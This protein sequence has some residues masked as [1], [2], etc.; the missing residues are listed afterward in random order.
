MARQQRKTAKVRYRGAARRRNHPYVRT[1]F[2]QALGEQI[3]S[4]GDTSKSLI[5]K[6]ELETGQ[7]QIRMLAEW[8]TG[9]ST[10]RHRQSRVVL[11]KI[12]K[13]YGLPGG[14]FAKLITQSRPS[15]K[16]KRRK[17]NAFK[18]ALNSLMAQFGDS[19]QSLADKISG[20]D[21]QL[22]AGALTYWKTG[23]GV[24]RNSSSNRAMLKK[25]E[26]HYQLEDGFLTSLIKSPDTPTRLVLKSVPV[27][28]R[29]IMKWHLPADFDRRPEGERAEILGWIKQNVE[30]SSTAYGRYQSKA[31]RIG[32]AIV[33]PDIEASKGGR[34]PRFWSYDPEPQRKTGEFGTV[35]APPALSQEMKELIDLKTASLP[36]I[37]KRRY[38]RWGSENAARVARQ[39]GTLFGAMVAPSDSAING[40]DVPPFK[41][42]LGLLAFPAVWEWF[43]HWREQ[44]RGFLS[45]SERS[46]LYDAKGLLH[47]RT[48]WLRQNPQLAYRLEPILGLLSEEDIREAQSD[49]QGLCDS[50]Y[51]YVTDCI[52]GIRQI[53]RVHRDPFEP[54]LVV[55]NAPR[56]LEI[57]KRI[58]DEILKRGPDEDE[59]RVGA[60]IAARSYLLVRFA[61]QLGIRQ[62]NLRQLMLCPFQ[63][64]PRSSGELEELRR[65]EL[66]WNTIRSAWEVFIPAKAFKNGESSYFK[67]R[68][69]RLFLPDLECLYDHIDAYLGKHRPVLVNGNPDPGTVFIRSAH[70]SRRAR[71]YDVGGFYQ[72]WRTIIQRYGIYNPYTGKGAIQG[73]L[74]HGPHAIRDV[75]ATHVLKQTGSYELAGYAI[76]D[77]T[78]VVMRHYGRYF[79]HEK[80]ERA[81]E[82][83]NSVWQDAQPFEKSVTATWGF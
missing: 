22:G 23:R 2:S 47:K 29:T 26:Q 63:G 62:R 81:A 35:K 43:L 27:S 73:L 6:L 34:N 52:P 56:P 13:H 28:F 46:I 48:G 32:F 31:T 55:L 71:I 64:A 66:R 37:G 33:F 76:Q 65:G 36:P 53:L 80:A 83:L 61:M 24:P 78:E 79:P 8:R 42:T 67:G 58:A 10:P 4:H 38:L 51:D 77:T 7:R 68:P 60:A 20:H 82:I 21:C 14:Y 39:L 17:L 19:S 45:E 15:F 59:D 25:I 69:Y 75:I 72:V 50:G 57:Y 16:G 1:D 41:L 49:W 30:S 44:R 3:K 11:G 74:P 70:S 12:E 40:L 18:F 9:R 5:K 54:I